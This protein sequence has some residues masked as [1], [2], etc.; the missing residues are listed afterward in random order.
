MTFSFLLLAP[1]LVARTHFFL[2]L[3]N[4]TVKLLWQPILAIKA[5]FVV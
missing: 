5:I 3:P 4:S 2:S 1:A